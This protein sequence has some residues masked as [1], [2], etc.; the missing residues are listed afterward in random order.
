[1]TD[2]VVVGAGAIGGTIGA[3][4]VRDGHS[5]LF[6]DAAADHV[7]GINAGGLAIEGP[8][9]TF[10]AHAP[11]VMPDDLPDGLSTV[12]LAVKSQHTEDALAAI[13]PR[14]AP[15]GFIVSLQNGINEPLIA[16]RVGPERTV[17]AFVNFGADVVA[18]GR[19]LLGGRGAFRVGEPD[20]RASDRA[21]T[22]G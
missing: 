3:R 11:A 5:V 1:M 16:G 20:G 15:D 21:E 19:I 2:Y 13:A 8:V 14:L 22:S 9:E 18:P 7:N 4:L 10:T 6:C 17:G 12:L